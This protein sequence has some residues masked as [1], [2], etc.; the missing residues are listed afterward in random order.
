[1]SV[2]GDQARQSLYV[3]YRACGGQGTLRDDPHGREN[4]SR[5]FDGR[6]QALAESGEVV[7][8]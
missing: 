7:W 3:S 2:S 1:M 6:Q 8:W 5:T 4:I